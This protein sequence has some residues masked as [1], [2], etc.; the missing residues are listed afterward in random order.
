[1]QRAYRSD[2]RPAIPRQN[3]PM[4]KQTY[5]TYAFQVCRNQGFGNPPILGLRMAGWEM[6]KNRSLATCDIYDV[7]T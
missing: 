5:T 6:P 1:M 7:G 2:R 3:I 4:T